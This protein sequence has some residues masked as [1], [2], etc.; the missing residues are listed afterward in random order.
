MEFLFINTK[1]H[2][3]FLYFSEKSYEPNIKTA[4]IETVINLLHKKYPGSL[5]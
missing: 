3:Y 5:E 2:A 4:G 1:N